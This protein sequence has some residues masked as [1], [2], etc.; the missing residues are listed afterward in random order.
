MGS[1]GF[2]GDLSFNPA[3]LRSLRQ[4]YCKHTLLEADLDLRQ[5]SPRTDYRFLREGARK[6]AVLALRQ[7]SS[8]SSRHFAGFSHGTFTQRVGC[9]NRIGRLGASNTAFALIKINQ[10][11]G[12]RLSA[13]RGYWTGGLDSHPDPRAF[14]R[15]PPGEQGGYPPRMLSQTFS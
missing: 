4:S 15:W 13:R 8:R 2:D 11:L 1:T 6:A 3:C 5:R 7:A 9:Q 10:S 14:G 12:R